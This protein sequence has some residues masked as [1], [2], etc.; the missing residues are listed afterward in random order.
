[1]Q[2]CVIS[3]FQMGTYNPGPAGYNIM[4]AHNTLGMV[5]SLHEWAH[6][7]AHVYITLE[8]PCCGVTMWHPATR[9]AAGWQVC[10]GV[11]VTT[12]HWIS[13][14]YSVGNTYQPV[15]IHFRGQF[16]KHSWLHHHL[17]PMNGY[18]LIR[19]QKVSKCTHGS[20]SGAWVT[21]QPIRQIEK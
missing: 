12:T 19:L 15:C 4:G 13:I 16:D 10:W 2:S 20:C 11:C 18:T 6:E 17:A 5:S 21:M 7:W 3:A 9:F 8:D 14:Y 1:M